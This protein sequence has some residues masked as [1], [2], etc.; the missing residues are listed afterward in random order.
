VISLENRLLRLDFDQDTGAIRQ[1][2]HKGRSLRLVDRRIEAESG[3]WVDSFA[4]FDYEQLDEEIRFHWIATN[5]LEVRAVVRLPAESDT[6][7]FTIDIGD[8]DGVPVDKIEYPI[9]GGIGSLSDTV[10]SYLAHPQGTGFVF[11]NPATLFT[12]D[13]PGI[14]YSPYPEG[15][16]GSS[17]QSFS[18]YTEDIGGF[19]FSTHDATGAM[20]WLNF[21]RHED[22]KLRTSFMHQSPDVRSGRG[23]APGYEVRIGALDEGTWYEAA[24]RYKTWA[25]R[26]PWTSRGLI[27]DRPNW[28]FDEVG[29]VTFG[30]N[31]AHDRSAWLDYFHKIADAPV[32]HIIGVNWPKHGGDYH[33]VH[34]G[35]RDDW[36]PA[37]FNQVNLET[38]RRNG[39][40]WAPFEFDLLQDPARS[41]SAEVRASLVTF[42]DD[43]Y[44]F[45]AYDFPFQCPTVPYVR[46]LHAWRDEKLVTDYDADGIYY[47]ISAN[48]VLMQCRLQDHGHPVGGGKW[49]VDAYRSLWSETGQRASMAKGRHVPQ[50]AEMV[51][52]VFLDRLDFY[53]ARAEATPLAPFESNFFRDWIINGDC[54]KIPLFTYVYHEYGPVRMDGW[55]KLSR[56]TGELWFWVAARVVIWGGLFELNYEFSPLEVLDGVMEDVSQHYATIDDVRRE[57]DPARAEFVRELVRSRIG[58]AK[59]YLVHG[60]MLRPLKFDGPKIDLDWTFF[61]FPPDSPIYGQS[62]T[63]R[64][65]LVQHAAWRAPDGRLGFVFINL[66]PVEVVKTSLEIDLRRYDVAW[67]SVTV[68]Q[69]THEESHSLFDGNTTNGLEIDVHLSS[70]RVTV[71]EVSPLAGA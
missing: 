64:V 33:G 9:I 1:A 25:I 66:H 37:R 69:H 42:Q 52:E 11:R 24:D 18:Y 36:F 21:W 47:D 23:F 3:T 48:N 17:L 5:G 51:N 28:L 59:P 10:D 35:G 31:S 32:F 45:D 44:S 22:G 53:Q 6:A 2:E 61:N 43:R 67:S 57:I 27:A 55:G 14:R 56:E 39:D 34:P 58:F 7:S 40:Y 62:A 46:E 8:L 41:E 50:G 19:D 4:S 49:I 16:S 63:Q 38:I 65:D 60:T 12:D 26:Q 29:I 54:E 71:I 15:F 20:K 68:K 13:K 70:R 30:I